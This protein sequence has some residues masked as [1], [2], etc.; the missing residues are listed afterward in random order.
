MQWNRSAALF[1]LLSGL[2]IGAT[3]PATASETQRTLLE[4]IAPSE[5]ELQRWQANAARRLL[6]LDIPEFT[7]RSATQEDRAVRNALFEQCFAG[8]FNQCARHLQANRKALLQALPSN[9]DYW[10]AFWKFV[11]QPNMLD[12]ETDFR[13]T[14]EG[15]EQFFKASRWWLIRDLIDNGLL[16]IDR[17]VALERAIRILGSGFRQVMDRTYALAMRQDISTWASLAAAQASRSADPSALEALARTF[18]PVAGES[19]SWGATFWAENE[20]S[21]RLNKQL[22]TTPDPADIID[23]RNLVTHFDSEL[24]AE[25]IER[26]TEDPALYI[27]MG[28]SR[29]AEHYE[30]YSSQS[31]E[32][33]WSNGVTPFSDADAGIFI[34]AAVAAPAYAGYIESERQAQFATQLYPALLDIYQGK[35]SPGVPARAAPKHWRWEWRKGSPDQLCLSSD[36][37]HQ[38]TVSHGTDLPLTICIEYFSNSPV[39]FR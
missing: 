37:I 4:R 28:N 32:A 14:H 18:Q 7:D 21:V 19:L 5:A 17:I 25:E 11:S 16:Q 36:E 35:T 20:Q 23:F 10:S 12:L 29:V 27:T 31:W 8:S 26:L 1:A 34:L 2:T 3:A 24:S 38:S 30:R 33:Y 15:R 39:S 6:L 13:R 22:E 9:P